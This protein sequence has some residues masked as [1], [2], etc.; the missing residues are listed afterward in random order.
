CLEL[1][2]YLP[3]IEGSIPA[4]PVALIRELTGFQVELRASDDVDTPDCRAQTTLHRRAE[5]GLVPDVGELRREI[6]GY[7]LPGFES[8]LDA[9][10]PV[11]PSGAA[12][13]AIG[14]G[15]IAQPVNVGDDGAVGCGDDAPGE[16]IGIVEKVER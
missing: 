16:G 8:A 10:I 5:L 2:F 15:G 13:I 12:N 6:D 9:Q 14:H 1:K 4:R 3:G 7:T 11:V